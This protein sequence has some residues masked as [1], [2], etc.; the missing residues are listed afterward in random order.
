MTQCCAVLCCLSRIAGF[1]YRK[2]EYMEESI[3]EITPAEIFEMALNL[4]PFFPPDNWLKELHKYDTA[5]QKSR[6]NPGHNA[7]LF[8]GVKASDSRVFVWSIS[9]I[10]VE[11]QLDFTVSVDHAYLIPLESL[12][13]C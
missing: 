5:D 1:E 4:L 8:V 2:E 12:K 10:I 3:V 9:C 13:R 6:G 11:L 7:K